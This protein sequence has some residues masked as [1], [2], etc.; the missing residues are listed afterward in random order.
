MA[1]SEVGRA[2]LRAWRR[3]FLLLSAT[4]I[5]AL[6]AVAVSGAAIIPATILGTLAIAGL[7]LYLSVPRRAAPN[8][9]ASAPPAQGAGSLPDS[10]REVFECIDDP[11]LILDIAGRVVYANHASQSLVGVDAERKRI[12]AVL[13]NPEVLE[14]VERVLAGG[15]PETIVFSVPVPVQRH[16]EANIARTGSSLVLVRVRD[17]TAMRRAEELRADFV[18]NA[19]HELRTPLAAVKGFIDT[20][21]GDAEDD[22]E[23]LE[24]FPHV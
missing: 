18:A 8:P 7:A 11:L 14:A 19:S 23:A 10:A 22:A 6:M 16:Y 21:G 3:P 20:F 2:Q 24:L 17:L 1:M 4:A 5:V 9:A 15:D 12:S 13:R